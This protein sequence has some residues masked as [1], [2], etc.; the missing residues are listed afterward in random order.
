MN[1]STDTEALENHPEL[2]LIRDRMV[3]VKSASGN[4]LGV[5]SDG[6]I[7]TCAH[8]HPYLPLGFV[9]TDLFEVERIN[10]GKGDFAMYI[11]TSL[12]V[13]LLAQDGWHCGL[14]EG[15]TES[16][17][18]VIYAVEGSEES[19]FPTKIDFKSRDERVVEGFFFGKD[20]MTVH[21]TQFFLNKH[22]ESIEFYSESIESG[23]SGGPIFTDGFHLIGVFTTLTT[24]FPISMLKKH[25]AI[26]RRIDLSLPEAAS[27]R[28]Q[29]RQLTF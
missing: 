25:N 15:P 22:D 6:F 18:N 24:A 11:A 10:G 28:I 7:I 21:R 4:G 26:G 8:I 3:F 9:D 14:S 2:K 16:A 27:R 1:K 12:D 5:L 13:M 17:K 29:W 19:Q 20:G 23:C